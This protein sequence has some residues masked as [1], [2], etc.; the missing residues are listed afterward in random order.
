M[1]IIDW[2]GLGILTGFLFTAKTNFLIEWWHDSVFFVGTIVGFFVF[3]LNW[4][5]AIYHAWTIDYQAQ[6]DIYFLY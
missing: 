6:E 4:L 5:L 3:I 2:T 1:E